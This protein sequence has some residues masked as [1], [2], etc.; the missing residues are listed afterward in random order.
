MTTATMT[1]SASPIDAPEQRFLFGG[2]DWKFYEQI[3][4][5]L[6]GRRVQITYDRGRLEILYPSW[7]QMGTGGS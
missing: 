1:E 3:L 7:E 5:R 6:D 2:A 4:R